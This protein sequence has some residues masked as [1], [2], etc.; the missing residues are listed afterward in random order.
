MFAAQRAGEGG[1]MVLPHTYVA[2][3]LLAILSMLCWGSW[4]NSYK[5]TGKWRFELFYW[6]YA[7]GVLL[8]GVVAALTFGSLGFDGFLFTDDLLNAGRRP[9]VYGLAAGVTFN[10]GNMLLLAA[11]AVAGM[12]V[13]FP[14]GMGL[15]LIVGV[16]WNQILKPSGNPTLLFAGSLLVVAAILLETA[17]YRAMSRSRYEGLIKA[18]KTRSTKPKAS[19][20]AILVSVPAGLLIG[21]SWPLVDLSKQGGLGPYSIG[22]LFAAGIFFSTLACNIFF[23]NLPVEGEP[24]E[25]R[26]YFRGRS[27]QHLLGVLGGAVWATGLLAVLVVSSATKPLEGAAALDLA[28]PGEPLLNPAIG[29][30]LAQAATLL[31]ALWGLVVWRECRGAEMRVRAMVTLAFALFAGGLAL[32]AIAPLYV[33]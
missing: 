3:V 28:A 24:V 11:I 21:S 14:V 17:V 12:S 10:L 2:A 1:T 19:W 26:D 4:A 33:G 6:D 22:C 25:F 31:A 5:L 7:L 23:M 9:L 30:A 15:A 29:Y 32:V 13:A 16:V 20:K 27:S 18:G 8:V